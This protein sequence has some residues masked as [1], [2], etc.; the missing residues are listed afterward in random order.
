MLCSAAGLIFIN[1]LLLIDLLNRYIRGKG[2]RN[3]LPI[4]ALSTLLLDW[5]GYCT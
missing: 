1:V 5:N 4:Q 2:S 3:E